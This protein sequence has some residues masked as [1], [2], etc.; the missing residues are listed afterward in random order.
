MEYIQAKSAEL[1]NST[2]HYPCDTYT[3]FPAACYRYKVAWMKSTLKFEL[4][5]LAQECLKLESRFRLG[6]FHGIGF[7]YVY[8]IV[9]HPEYIAEVCSFGNADDQEICLEGAVEKLAEDDAQFA[10]SVCEYLEATN[11]EVCLRAVQNN[12]YSLTK[13]F[14]LYFAEA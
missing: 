11:K 1:K 5:E 3:R 10:Q 2:I 13:S 4:E 6:C 9:K 8:E 14:R 12:I 7:S